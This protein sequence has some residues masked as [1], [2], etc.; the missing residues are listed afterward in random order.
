MTSI[1]P[2]TQPAAFT[3][4]RTA[5]ARRLSK[6]KT[7]LILEHPF[8]GS[9]TLNMPFELDDNTKTAAT[10]GKWVKFNPAFI[11]PLTDDEL[12]FLV[13][14]EV[15]HPML[16]HNYRRGSR[17]PRKWNR[18]GDYVINELLTIDRVGTMP[19]GGL[20][21]SH[22]YNAGNGSTDGIYNILEDQDD[23]DGS[24]DGIGEDIVDADGTDAEVAQ[25]QSEMRVKV[26][27][28]AQAARMQGRLSDSMA[29]LVGEILNPKIAWEDVL[30]RFMTKSMNNRRTYARPNRRFLSHGMYLPSQSGEGL[31]EMVFAIDCSGSVTD[32]MIAQ[33]GGEVTKVFEDLKPSK[34]HVIYFHHEVSHVETFVQG[35]TL[36]FGSKE[37]G[38]T[39]FSPVFNKI[40]EM[41]IEP[42]ACV[43]LT[44]LYCSDFG[45]TPD[46]PVLWI[47]N[48]AQE[49]PFGEVVAW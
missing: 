44:D 1:M 39:A 30:W 3:G 29:R 49:A 17:N 16:E 48:G 21:D 33:S 23:D 2:T 31:G 26:A 9:I 19:A 4:D 15:F 7:S 14:H 22:T 32:E 37:T 20:Q 28:A 18:A 41:Q 40:D 46:Y 11:D 43:F 10:N 45:P 5:L 12:K 6:A 34:L 38:G 35:D 24:D 42:A 47:S 8:I 36:R 13:A 27:Q 25:Q